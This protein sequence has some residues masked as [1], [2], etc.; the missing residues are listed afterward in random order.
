MLPALE[1][2]EE[3][4]SSNGVWARARV[5]ESM[6]LRLRAHKRAPVCLMDLRSRACGLCARRQ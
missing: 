1:D 2:Q 6:Y 4:E 5:S 3:E